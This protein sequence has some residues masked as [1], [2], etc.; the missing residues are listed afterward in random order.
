MLVQ[1]RLRDTE[2]QLTGNRQKTWFPHYIGDK[3]RRGTSLSYR[4]P[5]VLNDHLD[6]GH[7]DKMKTMGR[8]GS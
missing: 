8:D 6:Y 4:G 7:L 5:A 3:D 2:K 1:S